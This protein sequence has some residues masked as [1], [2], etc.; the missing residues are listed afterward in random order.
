MD[1]TSVK[2]GH[3]YVSVFADVRGKKVLFVTEGKDKR[4]SESF[5]EEFGGVADP[6][7]TLKRFAWT[8]PRRSF[9]RKLVFDEGA[10]NEFLDANITFDG[11]T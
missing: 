4:T 7:P 10:L 11:F 5:N 8:C 9:M 3:Y 1:E 6:P 2:P